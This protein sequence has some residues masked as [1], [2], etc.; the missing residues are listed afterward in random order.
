MRLTLVY[1]WLS[2]LSVL[3]SAANLAQWQQRSIYQLVT[4]RFGFQNGTLDTPCD[5]AQ[6]QYCG[7]TW[8]GIISNLDYIQNMGFSAIWISP[9][10]K[11]MNTP[12]ADLSSYH[13]Y[14]TLD[15]YSLNP[16]FGTADDLKALSKALHDRGMYLM[17]DVVINHVA[18]PGNY[19]N[20]DYTNYVPFNN[21]EY[22]HPYC[23]IAE[24][25]ITCWLGEAIVELPDIKTEN[26]TVRQIYGAWASEL[27]SNYTIDGL[28]ID[29]AGNVEVGFFPTLS[30]SAGVFTIGEVYSGDASFGCSYTGSLDSVL[31][32]PIFFPLIRAFEAQTGDIAS[33]AANIAVVQGLCKTSTTVLGSFTENADQSRIANLTS[34]LSI[35]KTFLA[36]TF[37]TDGIPI[38]YYGQEQRFSG[39]L[40]PYNRESMWLANYNTSSPLVPYVTTLN[41][42]R[43]QFIKKDTNW[44]TS[45]MSVVYNDTHTIALR[46]GPIGSQTVL[47]LTNWGAT[48]VAGHAITLVQAA[49]GF[50][51]G[52]LITD[53]LNCVN[54]YVAS[55]GNLLVVIDYGLPLALYSTSN[56]GGS[57]ICINGTTLQPNPVHLDPITHPEIQVNE[58]FSATAAAPASA[59]SSIS[60]SSASSVSAHS[61]LLVFSSLYLLV[62]IFA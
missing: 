58:T 24:N 32:Y 44:A 27:V 14:W 4:D 8:Q 51:P 37:L 13:G 48:D 18:W 33:L 6:G 31:N 26:A 20:V 15:M 39:G 35:A 57:N 62:T 45:M 36:Y 2:C 30:K 11:Q 3:I 41:V 9:I 52:D 55:N 49:H 59:T 61:V 50:A 25:G 29:A 42:V 5:P 56:L 28:R 17:V 54:R 23:P 10:V 43:N 53:T 21:A 38:L 12:T 60:P 46:K 19:T 47:V 40:P 22:Y 34:D 16:N 7:G 1:T